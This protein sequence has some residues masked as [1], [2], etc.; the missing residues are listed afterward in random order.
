MKII[1]LTKFNCQTFPIEEEDVTIDI[2]E[3]EYQGL[4]DRSKC[5]NSDLTAV[6]DYV[7]TAEE[8][9]VKTQQ[10]NA[11]R[12]VELKNLLANTDYQAI[13]FAEGE[14]TEAEYGDTKAQRIAWRVE[15][16]TL[17]G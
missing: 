8:L 12:I 9:A 17:E 5:F 15:I 14:L 3:E 4:I 2:T 11:Q 6:I 1:P 10:A 13:K 16:N 7:P